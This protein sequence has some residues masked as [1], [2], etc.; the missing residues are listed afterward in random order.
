MFTVVSYRH[1]YQYCT[2][3]S[4]KIRVYDYYHNWILNVWEGIVIYHVV[5][6]YFLNPKFNEQVF[7]RFIC[8]D[9]QRVIQHAPKDIKIE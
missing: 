1:N 3:N 7:H 6:P 2:T 9:W 4:Y 5:G 8:E